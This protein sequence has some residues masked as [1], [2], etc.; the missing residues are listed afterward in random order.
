VLQ[1]TPAR[2]AAPTTAL[3][4]FGNGVHVPRVSLRVYSTWPRRVDSLSRETALDVK[5]G[6]SQQ[7]C[8]QRCVLLW[9]LKVIGVADIQL[10]LAGTMILLDIPTLTT[11][12]LRLRAFPFWKSAFFGIYCTL[13]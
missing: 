3:S 13:T 7:S 5:K 2:S 10:P 12:R 4:G 9:K 6:V 8:R 1:V 11:D